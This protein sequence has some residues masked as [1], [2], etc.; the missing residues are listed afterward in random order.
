MADHKHLKLDIE[1]AGAPVDC[2]KH[3]TVVTPGTSD[4]CSVTIDDKDSSG[5][6]RNRADSDLTTYKKSNVVAFLCLE[7]SKEIC[8]LCCGVC[9]VMGMGLSF[10][11]VVYLLTLYF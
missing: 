11:V 2:S 9:I 7:L 5:P 8:R 3:V 4:I 10:G 1:L 6:R